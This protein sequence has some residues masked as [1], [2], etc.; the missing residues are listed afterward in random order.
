[1]VTSNRSSAMGKVQAI[2]LQSAVETA[3]I[4]TPSAALNQ[5]FSLPRAAAQ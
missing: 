4:V 3:N 1:M 5:Q 2:V